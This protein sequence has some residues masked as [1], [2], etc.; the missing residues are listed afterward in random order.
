L[1]PSGALSAQEV[2][3]YV[4]AE[5]TANARAA[6]AKAGLT[7][8]QVR[9]RHTDVRAPDS[10][11]ISDRKATV[12]SVPAPSAELFRMIRKGRLEWRAELTSAELGRIAPGAEVQV[13]AANG[14]VMK[15]KVRALAPT[16][17]P[18]NRATLVYVDLAPPS[19][20]SPAPSAGMFAR[21]EFLL[22]ATVALTVPQQALV[23]REGF[24]YVFSV[25]PD[26]RVAQRKVQTG[27]QSGD[28]VEILSGLSAEAQLAME[29]AGF[30]NDGDL[31]RVVAPAAAPGPKNAKPD[32]PAEKK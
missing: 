24:S 4:T 20:K 32:V 19:G 18:N 22:G 27:R 10:G 15:G 30:L 5:Q 11:I 1:Q 9:L 13:T 25:G 8:Q 2:A 6:S 14:S 3:R 21:G 12:G 28:R 26:E 17:D 31:V 7:A 16:V 29:G 23:M